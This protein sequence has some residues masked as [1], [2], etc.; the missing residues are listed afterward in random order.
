[1][2]VDDELTRKAITIEALSF[3]LGYFRSLIFIATPFDLALID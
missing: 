1:L 3:L 2:L